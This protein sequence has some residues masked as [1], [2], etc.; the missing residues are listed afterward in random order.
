MSKLYAYCRVS[1]QKQSLERQVRNIKHAYPDILDACIYQDKYTGTKMDRPKWGKLLER[2]EEDLQK[3]HEITLVFDEVS[4]M[5]RNAE[6]GLAT[7]MELFNKG[8]NLV[9][10]NDHYADS[11]VYKKAMHEGIAMTGTNADFI[12]KGINEYLIALAKE[13]I[14]IAFDK[15]EAELKSKSRNT[16]GGIE[17]ARL[18]GKQIGQKKGAKLTTKKSVEMKAKIRKMAKDFDGNMTDKEVIETLNLARNTYYKY[19]KEMLEEN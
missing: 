5:S 4:R 8:V 9:F 6:E 10:L 16:S 12:L 19:K 3:G 13:Q 11:A 7:Y 18:N 15:A 14:K 1:T 2:I 17:T